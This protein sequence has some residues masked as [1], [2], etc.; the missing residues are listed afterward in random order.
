V[1]DF[2]NIRTCI[3]VLAVSV[4]IEQSFDEEKDCLVPFPLLNQC[5]Q[6]FISLEYQ[7]ILKN[8]LELQS[9]YKTPL[10]ATSKA[11]IE[12]QIQTLVN[13]SMKT[14]YPFIHKAQFSTFKALTEEKVINFF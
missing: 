7:R 5:K 11:A 14:L 3:Q 12:E 8:L 9:E 4:L 10:L 6:N 1:T 13:F 2:F